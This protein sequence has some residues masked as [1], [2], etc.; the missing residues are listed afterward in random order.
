MFVAIESAGLDPRA[1]A[2]CIDI[3][4]AKR[5]GLG[6]RRLHGGAKD[7]RGCRVEE[8]GFRRVQGN[9]IQKRDGPVE[10]DFKTPAKKL[11]I[12]GKFTVLGRMMMG[13]QIIDGIR[14]FAEQ[15]GADCIRIKEVQISPTNTDDLIA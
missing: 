13:R 6:L 10:M 7:M 14:I 8:S 1:L 11:S 15:K 4:G 2:D 3:L 12:G 9:G 5:G